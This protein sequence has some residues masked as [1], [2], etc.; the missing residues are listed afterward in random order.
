MFSRICRPLVALPILA[1]MT[2]CAMASPSP[3][4]QTKRIALV[5]GN[6]EYQH[7]VKLP[8]PA[9]DAKDI[10]MVLERLGFQVTSGTDLDYN[11]MRL[12]IRDFAE[13]AS[14]AD[15]SLVY[16]A[17]HGVEID[18][19]NYLIPVNAQLRRDRDV[20][21]EAIRLEA[22]V[23]ALSDTKGLKIVLV[24]A[25]RN[26]PFLVDMVRTSATRSIGR[27]LA[28]MDP[29]GV[30]V[31]YAAR[32]G[33]L[34]LDGEGRNSPYAQ[35][36]LRHI[37]EPG[38]EIGKLFRKVRDTVYDVTGGAQ[39]PFTY[40]S[41]PG[42]DI[43]L[44]PAVAPAAGVAAASAI[45]LQMVE[46]FASVDA[47][48][49]LRGWVEF[50][51]RYAAYRDNSLMKL[52]VARRDAMQ[53]SLDAARD[54]ANRKPWL[55][56]TFKF[57]RPEM[58]KDQR[59]LFQRSLSYMGFDVGTPD[60]EF[61]PRTQRA[62][63]AARFKAGLS[64]GTHIDPALLKVIPDPQAI[65]A[66]KSEKARRFLSAELPQHGDSR[67]SDA[68]KALGAS[69]VRFG[70]FEG[71]LYLA[72]LGD[73]G[74]TE[75]STMA[76]R[77]GGHLVTIGSAAENEFVVEL[78]MAD[79]RFVQTASDGYQH[80]PFIGLFQIPGS[81]EPRGGWTWETGEPLS[82]TAWSQDNP[83]NFNGN[84]NIARFFRHRNF[85]GTRTLPRF[86]DD[87]TS[88]ARGPGFIIEIE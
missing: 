40:G 68:I 11:Q 76:R 42:E 15:V 71:R 19:T 22:V 31:G 18:N 56:V 17:G 24:D 2:L 27:G 85:S 77:A 45:E 33:T 80:G 79:P 23:D 25:C 84:Q 82:F 53:A 75:A 8:N 83:D 70:Y 48:P 20:D 5:I 35:A 47:R 16:F 61:G 72:V 86:W 66:L 65:D 21:F 28:R 50:V 87:T 7:V 38:L 55:E 73:F 69:E 64:A 51:E 9:N 52:A 63:S 39:E 3:A 60:G 62:I 41:L 88:G 49:T 4:N 54:A 29:S 46:D 10:G 36:L 12:A 37:E 57:G 1:V 32:G 58:T 44:I 78:F 26:N 14:N 43:F 30:L 81:P 34:A 13:V 67:F 6:A 74:W 59:V